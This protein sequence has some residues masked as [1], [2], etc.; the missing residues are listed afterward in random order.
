MGQTEI[1]LLAQAVPTSEQVKRPPQ[2]SSVIPT[3]PSV[4]A[5]REALHRADEAVRIAEIVR[6]VVRTQA[7]FA[8]KDTAMTDR[9]IATA[10]GLSKSNVNR[11]L[12]SGRRSLTFSGEDYEPVTEAASTAWGMPPRPV[13]AEASPSV[14]GAEERRLLRVAG[15]DTPESL[16]VAV[17]LAREVL[18]E[19]HP[20]AD[21]TE[22]MLIVATV[23]VARDPDAAY[24][25]AGYDPMPEGRADLRTA[26]ERGTYTR[27]GAQ[28]VR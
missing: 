23:Q 7:S 11:L 10:T 1:P 16:R 19:L 28:E 4:E 17:Q 2:T 27:A 6:G 18:A 12:R 14:A 21:V 5:V 15:L 3:D 13:V 8:L 24:I 20:K 25:L 9:A 22:G 26:R